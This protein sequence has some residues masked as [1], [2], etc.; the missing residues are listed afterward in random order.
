[1]AVRNANLGGTDFSDNEVLYD[2]DLDDTFNRAIDTY[3]QVLDQRYGDSVL[4]GCEITEQ[5]SPNQTVQMSSG[6]VLINGLYYS[7]SADASISLSAA[8]A[9]NPRWDLIS[10][11]NADTITVTD[12]TAAATPVVPTLP[13]DNVPLAVIYRAAN[14]NTIGTA[15]IKDCRR[16]IGQQYTS[17]SA[18]FVTENSATLQTK[19]TITI[20]AY[21]L[22]KYFD[23][24]GDFGNYLGGTEVS[25]SDN[26]DTNYEIARITAS[27]GTTSVSANGYSVLWYVGDTS[28]AGSYYS[29]S[30]GQLKRRVLSTELDF[31]K[32]ITVILYLRGT[33]SFTSVGSE[34]SGTNNY[35][36]VSG[37]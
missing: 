18:S 22:Q 36:F 20:P 12:G 34:V 32:P 3:V 33:G 26:S 5:S 1:M 37:E 17:R 28:P 13:A 24:E 19:K 23:M 4:T 2:Y 35:L 21:R 15:D 29:G 6:K 30:N 31:T 11:N 9:T 16:L 27:D 8:D 14:D 7:V 10:V 25:T